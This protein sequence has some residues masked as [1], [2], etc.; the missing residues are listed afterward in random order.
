[1]GEM[2]GET[3]RRSFSGWRNIKRLMF[4]AAHR[5]LMYNIYIYIYLFIYV[6]VYAYI[7]L[8]NTHIYIYISYT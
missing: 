7:P 3:W 8:L 5:G 4:V 2:G 6:Y 1:M